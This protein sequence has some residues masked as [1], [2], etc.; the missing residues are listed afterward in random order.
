MSAKLTCKS[1]DPETGVCTFTFEYPGD[2]RV[3]TFSAPFEEIENWWKG[4]KTIDQM[5]D[6]PFKTGPGIFDHPVISFALFS[7]SM[8]LGGNEELVGAEYA[9]T[10][11]VKP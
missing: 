1:K 10:A 5:M 11:K 3:I 4:C 6:A 7:L 2:K 8:M 9:I